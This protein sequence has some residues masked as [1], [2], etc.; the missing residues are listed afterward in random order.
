[1]SI[2]HAPRLILTA[3]LLAGAACQSA[4]DDATREA[5][6]SRLGSV[7]FTVYP[8]YLHSASGD[9]WDRASA[10]ALAAAIVEEGWGQAAPAS[11]DLPV[12]SEPGINQ[13]R[14]WKE[15]AASFGAWIAAHPPATDYAVQA[16][17]L[18]FDP[19]GLHEVGGIH[20]YVVDRSGKLVDGIL[21]NSHHD[22]FRAAHPKTAAECT[23]VLVAVLREEWK[24]PA[25]A[26]AAADR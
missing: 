23:A 24:R 12:H 10:E 14:M 18:G 8:T 20:A 6:R 21:L 13:L 9:A 3:L 25:A 2:P 11:E 4:I 16:E 19:S 7:S 15:S 22:G 26:T 5:F 1:M 17:D